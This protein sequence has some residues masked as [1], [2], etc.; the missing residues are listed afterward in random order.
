M[1][2]LGNIAGDSPSSRDLVLQLDVLPKI[3]KLI[4]DRDEGQDTSLMRNTV[5]ALSNLCR[6]KPQPDFDVIKACL[7]ALVHIIT[8]F[9]DEEVV[10]DAAWALSYLSD[11]GD[12]NIHLVAKCGIVKN[13]VGLLSHHNLNIVTPVLR[14]IGNLVTGDDYCTQIVLDEGL[15]N[16]MS[17]LLYAKKKAIR[18]ETCWTISNITAGNKAQI[19]S[20]IEAGLIPKLISMVMTEQDPDILRESL[21]A[22]GNGCSGGTDL[23]IEYFVTV[24]IINALCRGLEGKNPNPIK[25]SLEAL[26]NILR[27][28]E[29]KCQNE[30]ENPYAVLV[31]ECG[32]LDLIE[33]LQ[34]HQDHAVY[35]QAVHL[36]E[37]Y[38]G[39]EEEEDVVVSNEN[40]QFSFG[41]AGNNTGGSSGGGFNF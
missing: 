20:V 26:D 10:T 7:P 33:Q 35:T 31:Y 39:V 36:L 5:W 6:G 25:V 15:V 12:E 37:N 17:G 27:A 34:G 4:C 18:K 3:V 1:W 21:W 8:H 40:G 13:I 32:G 38:F 41:H 29:K 16:Y 28:G 24:G 23:Q 11:G 30:E 22:L 9:K 2:A 19:Q 14:T